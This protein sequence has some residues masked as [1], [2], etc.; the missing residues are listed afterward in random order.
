MSRFARAYLSALFVLYAALMAHYVLAYPIWSALDEIAHYDYIDQL[1]AGR[2]PHPTDLI[3]DYTFEI[4]MEHFE[5]VGGKPVV[6]SKEDM[7]A[8]GRS[9]EAQQPPVYYLLMALP[10]LA[11]KAA[12]VYPPAQIQALRLMTALFEVLGAAAGGLVVYRL[13]RFG[14]FSSLWAFVIPVALLIPNWT[15]RAVIGNS[16]LSLLMVNL[17][18]FFALG[19]LCGPS[20]RRNGTLAALF[21]ALAFLTKYTNLLATG[22]V[23]ALALAGQVAEARRS[24]GRFS[25]WRASAALWPLLLVAVFLGINVARFGWDDPLGARSVTDMFS[26]ITVTLWGPAYFEALA[27]TSYLTEHL[28]LNFPAHY[29]I[30]AGGL[31]T[32]VST[33]VYLYR[34]ELTPGL[35]WAGVLGVGGLL[36]VF[37]WLLPKVAPTVDWYYFRHYSG[38]LLLVPLAALGALMRPGRLEGAALAVVSAALAIPALTYLAGTIQAGGL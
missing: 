6:A 13:R 31:A 26:F 4:T 24:G 23:A 32:A 34:R 35:A 9:Y 38:Y 20:A 11:L 10:N 2:L 21:G 12:R 19:S 16:N 28:Y 17:A 33:G 36:A 25:L 18:F 37:A 29:L 1:G 5:W 22:A 27:R 8:A 7:L 3:S 30:A 14:G 15:W